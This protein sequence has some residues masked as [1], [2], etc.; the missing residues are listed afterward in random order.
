MTILIKTK[1]LSLV[2]RLKGK[3]V[4]TDDI[5]ISPIGA[6]LGGL[7]RMRRLAPD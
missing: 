1:I 4:A 2:D 3:R 5:I 6:Q 7:Q